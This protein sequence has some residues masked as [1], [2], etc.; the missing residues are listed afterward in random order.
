MDL[1][2]TLLLL[3]GGVLAGAV[4]A[5]GGGAS[6][7]TFPALLATGMSP[8][9]ANVTNWV[10]LM[11]G[12]FMAVLAYRGE[13]REMVERERGVKA[14]L[15][16]ALLGGVTGSLLLFWAG[17]AR[18]EK[19]VPWLMLTATLLFALGDWLRRRLL[20]HQGGASTTHFRLAL[21]VEF[22]MM[23]YGG[24][25]GAGLGIMLMALY[26]IMGETSI[27]R[28]NAMENLLVTGLSFSSG[29]IYLFSGQ[30]VWTYALPLFAGATLGGYGGIRLARRVPGQVL[31]RVVLSWASVLTAYMFWKYA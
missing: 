18:F 7:I 8:M 16:G 23:A 22:L 19:A 24:Y 1:P 27:H 13:L 9:I 20:A 29:V 12:N 3:A 31:R 11:P 6:F 30:V 21:G 26:T 28:A 15:L 4:A 2:L 14:R 25:F 10:A 17:Q 5:I